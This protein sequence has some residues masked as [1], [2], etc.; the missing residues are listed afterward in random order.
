MK[1]F[2]CSLRYINLLS[3]SKPGMFVIEIGKMFESLVLEL[4][5]FVE[6]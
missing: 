1:S 5:C 4:M 6:S 3:H 2:S